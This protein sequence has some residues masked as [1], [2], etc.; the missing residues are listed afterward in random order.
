LILMQ[1]GLGEAKVGGGEVR[2]QYVYI[3]RRYKSRP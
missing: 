2:F 1:V 3:V